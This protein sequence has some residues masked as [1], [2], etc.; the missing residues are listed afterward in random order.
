M[1]RKFNLLKRIGLIGILFICSTLGCSDEEAETPLPEPSYYPEEADGSVMPTG[2]HAEMFYTVL[3][4]VNPED[5]RVREPIAITEE[6]FEDIKELMSE[7]VKAADT[8]SV[9]AMFQWIYR[10]VKREGETSLNPHDILFGGKAANCQGFANVMKIA[11]LS[12]GIPATGVN[13]TIY[14]LYGQ[15]HACVYAYFGGRWLYLDVLGNFMCDAEDTHWYEQVFIP[16]FSDRQLMEDEDFVYGYD[17]GLSVRQV[18][19]GGEKLTISNSKNGLRVTGLALK[20]ELPDN[21]QEVYLGSSLLFLGTQASGI[22]ERMPNVRE[23]F[24]AAGNSAY[25]VENG[26]IYERNFNGAYP[27]YIPAKLEVVR[28]RSMRVVPKS[29]ISENAERENSI[30]E[31]YF[32]GAT[33]IEDYAVEYCPLLERVHVPQSAEIGEHAF[34]EGCEIV[35]LSE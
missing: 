30:R 1:N 24:I 12:Q 31:I 4:A 27:F 33:R 20:E 19:Q 15:G 8:D 3:A 2:S 10:N 25:E 14:D 13:G 21:V 5:C 7:V 9:T 26:I 17:Q 29:I 16:L 34:P 18:K 32:T 11:C 22:K 28:L 6:E 23:I 35:Y